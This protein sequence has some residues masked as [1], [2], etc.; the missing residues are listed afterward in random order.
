MDLIRALRIIRD[1]WLMVAGITVGTIIVAVGVATYRNSTIDPVNRAEAPITYISDLNEMNDPEGTLL[2]VVQAQLEEARARAVQVN[3][4]LLADPDN[5]VVVDSTLGRITFIARDADADEAIATAAEMRRRLLTRQPVNME[6]Q[7]EEQ[8]AGLS[9]QIDT[10][11]SQI[12]ELDAQ[13]SLPADVLARRERLTTLLGQLEAQA[14]DL[15]QR[16]LVP[17]EGED[18]R[19]VEELREELEQVNAAIEETTAELS[20]LAA[21]PGEFS[22][23][24]TERRALERQFRELEASYQELLL[25]RSELSGPPVVELVDV[26]DETP[27]PIPRRTAAA[28]A[29]VF[30]LGLAFAALLVGEKYRRPVWFAEDVPELPVIGTVAHRAVTPLPWYFQSGENDRKAEIQKLRASVRARAKEGDLVVGIARSGA[31]EESV[32]AL[33][34]DLS[35]SFASTGT[36]TALVDATFSEEGPPELSEPAVSL[37]ELL[38]ESLTPDQVSQELEKATN[39]P[40]TIHPRLLTVG[41]GQWAAAASDVLAGPQA[42][43]M[44][45]ALRELMDAVVVLTGDVQSPAT[46]AAVDRTDLVIVA[47][48]PGKTTLSVI[49]RFLEEMSVRGVEVLGVVLPRPFAPRTRRL[50]G[51][52]ATVVK[53]RERSTHEENEG[54]LARIRARFARRAVVLSRENGQ[55]VPGSAHT[56]SERPALSPVPTPVIQTSAASRAHPPKPAEFLARLNHARPEDLAHESEA[57]LADWVTTL[58]EARPGSGLTAETLREIDRA[59]FI[60]LS[61]WKNN[62]SLGSRLRHEFRA[63]LGRI[64][65][66]RLESLLLKSLSG[67]HDAADVTSLDRWVSRHYFEAHARATDWEPT[68]WHLTSPDGTVSALVAADRLD[69]RRVEAFV[70]G[71]VI[72]AIERLARRQRRREASG[73]DGASDLEAQIEDTRA[74]G[75]ALAWLM[76]GSNEESRLFYPSRSP[77]EQPEGWHPDW[78]EGVKANIAPLQRLGILAVPVLTQDELSVLDPTG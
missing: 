69:A 36:E 24:M 44:F 54:L 45:D 78:G 42:G 4:D 65:A 8:L 35:M 11:R 47:I 76:E 53:K 75:L 50:I 18:A 5:E 30:G 43:Y 63:A 15:E 61:T 16:I 17:E 1:R 73:G 22:P 27:S 28:A 14:L 32:Q 39:Q 58:V 37:G 19:P 38:S 46:R 31:S 55:P 7:I 25:Q 49:S 33:A 64:D 57:F 9:A 29:V 40:R 26:F 77:D 52:L 23:E 62:P 13:T 59:G 6:S 12:D 41:T 70:D 34:A 21:P 72:R 48:E 2:Q 68:V 10:V 67:I 51:R 74:L 71:I 60:P 56:S 20:E 3:A 66:G